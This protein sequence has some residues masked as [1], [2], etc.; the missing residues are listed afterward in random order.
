MGGTAAKASFAGALTSHCVEQD[1]VEALCDVLLATRADVSSKVADLRLTGLYSDEELKPGSDFGGYKVV[2]KLG[3][4]RLAISY[5]VKQGEREYRLKLLRSEATRDARGLHRFLTVTRLAG[6]VEH[7]GLPTGVAA[8]S[9][10]GRTGVVHHHVEGVPLA[11]RLARSG[12]L[13]VNEARPFLKSILEALAALHEQRVA[14][15]DLRLEN[16]L[17]TRGADGAQKVVLVDAGTDR[18]RARARTNNGRAE[19]FSTVGSPSSVSPEQIRGLVA[20]PVSD[21][22]SF[23]AVLYQMLCGKP[24]FGDKPALETAFGHLMQDP[25]PPSSVAPR[26]W[27]PQE[28]DDLVLS[29]LDKNVSR[30]PRDA[31][32]VLELLEGRAAPP[33]QQLT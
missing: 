4:G 14:H 3:E 26:G 27:I 2:R 19:L 16:L 29:L 32:A 13:H 24:V 21:V 30:R 17:I 8:I 10:D 15:G 5:V 28:L 6:K 22:Y 23:G 20:E 18:L 33:R 25:S 7:P 9:V 1:A 11:Q 31:K 12:P